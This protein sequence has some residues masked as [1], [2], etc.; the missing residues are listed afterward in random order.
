M[1]LLND[2]LRDLSQHKPVADGPVVNVGEGDELLLKASSFAKKKQQAWI[3]L[4]IFFVIVF[5]AVLSANYLLHRPANHSGPVPKAAESAASNKISHALPASAKSVPE[6]EAS[7]VENVEKNSPNL[8]AEKEV[9]SDLQNHIED[10]LLQA[11][12]A[13]NMDRLTAPV[14]D[15]AYGYYQ[16]ILTMDANNLAA[17]EGLDRI[18]SRY[19]AKAQEQINSSN[20]QQ[21]EAL[22]QRARFV[23]ER[24]VQA[25]EISTGANGGQSVAQLNEAVANESASVSVQ[26]EQSIK[27]TI[28]P[29]SVTEA[30]A[31]SVT[32]NAGWKD[33]QLAHH[34]QELIQQAKH[35]E[36]LALLKAF[37]TTEQKPAL[38][39][40]LLADLY[41]QQGNT[42]AADIIVEKASYLP[43]DVKAKLK[44]QILG[45]QGDEA[46]AIAVLEKNLSSAD[47]NES[48]RSLLAILYHKT[49]NYQQ[50][51]IS[52]QRLLNSFGD[53]PAYWLGLALAYDGLSQHKNALQAYQRLREFPQ[54]QEQVKKYTDQRIAALRSE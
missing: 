37:V 18:A 13:I 54:L 14:E 40:E 11:E 26:A 4:A 34:A 41:I 22:I 43:V 32:P 7:N 29:F 35:S 24:Y 53:K 5:V 38:S 20:L 48:Y 23:S 39:A 30:P 15:N 27:E 36:A 19:M 2:M 52:Y 8:S 9:T 31:V 49:A 3:P 17:K 42:Q 12:R 47:A 21:A 25:H 28:K 1:S 44:A 10:L 45:A 16:K 6:V 50:S 46:Q 33:E 51:I